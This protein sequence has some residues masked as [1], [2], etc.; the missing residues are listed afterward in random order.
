MKTG[1]FFLTAGLPGRVSIARFAPKDHRGLPRY[2]ALAPG[3]W[4]KSVP[5]EEYRRR[6]AA[7]LARLDPKIAWGDLHGLAD[8]AEP[9]LLCWERPGQFC[10]R[11]LV[12]GWLEDALGVQVPEH[13]PPSLQGDLFASTGGEE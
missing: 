7:Q 11:R 5:E 12:A 9:V 3:P 13:T 4:F 6:Y 1:S 2:G 10:H 8:D